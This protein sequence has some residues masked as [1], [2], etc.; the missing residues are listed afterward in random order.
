MA[1]RQAFSGQYVA[2]PDMNQLLFWMQRFLDPA[3]FPHDLIADFLQSSAPI[4]LKG[5]YWLAAKAGISLLVFSK[6]LPVALGLIVTVYL[7]ALFMKI[8]PVP[9]AA[10]VSTILLNQNQSVLLD[11]LSGTPRGFGYALF[12]PFLYYLLKRSFIAV[13]LFIA[14]Q[15]LFYPPLVF[16]SLGVLTLRLLRWQSAI[17]RLSR[18]KSDY[19]MFIAGLFTAFIVLLPYILQMSSSS[20]YGQ[21]VSLHQAKMMPEFSRYGRVPFF[22]LNPFTFWILGMDSGLLSA[23]WTMLIVNKRWCFSPLML[24]FIFFPFLFRYSSFFPLLKRITGRVTILAQVV[25]ASLVMY[26]AAHA[27]LYMLYAP[28]RYTQASFRLVFVILSAIT[29]IATLDMIFNICR[30][31][32][33]SGIKFQIISLTAYAAFLFAYWLIYFSPGHKTIFVC[34]LALGFIVSCVSFFV[35]SRPG[36][37]MKTG[38]PYPPGRSIWAGMATL[39]LFAAIFLFFPVSF[40]YRAS[41]YPKIHTFFARQPKDILIASLD[42]EANDIPLFAH[43]SILAGRETALPYRLGYYNQIKQRTMDMI[44]AQYSSNLKDLQDFINKYKINYF[45]VDRESFTPEYFKE[46]N[47]RNRWL[48][49]YPSTYQALQKLEQGKI[50][51]LAGFLRSCSVCESK[52]LIVLDAKCILKEGIK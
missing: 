27:A 49:L 9:F 20:G 29:L 21:M 17:P 35:D 38:K 51:A 43:R 19:S 32:K 50:P 4:G 18:D 6:I 22:G 45:V 2:G 5:V 26:F 13:L 48:R 14:L 42:N 47:W 33:K 30:R 37:A 1:L 44:Q 24:A 28:N 15:G 11:W 10:F 25:I 23:E 41:K 3:L 16:I 7:F 12:L 31:A 34:L 52:N 40:G 39:M 36:F 8:F 46:D